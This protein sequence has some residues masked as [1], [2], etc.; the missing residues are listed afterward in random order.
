MEA[1]EN[2][3]RGDGVMIYIEKNTEFQ[4]TEPTVVTIGKFDGRHRGHQKLLRTMLE[5][6]E[7]YGY[8]TAVFTFSIAPADLVQGKRH[9]VITTNLERKNNLRKMG[10]DYLVEYPFT[11]DVAQM[12]AED[13]VRDI[14]VKQMHAKAIV[15]GTDCGFGYRRMGNAALLEKLAPLYGYQL[16]VI[17]KERDE[18]RVISS[19]YVREK[20]DLGQIEKANALLGEPYYIHGQVVHG[21]HI[22]QPILGY[23]TANLLPPP[24]KHLPPFG[25]YVSRVLIDGRFYG[26][27]TNIG[28]KPTIP[29]KD[30]VA[31][32]GVETFVFDY[33]GNLYGKEIE[34]GLLHFV[35]PER[36]MS[37]LEEL[38]GQISRDKEV[39]QEYLASHPDVLKEDHCSGPLRP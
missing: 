13:F 4:I 26:G 9:T 34:V 35:R 10:M 2:V 17:E 38:K 3:S 28:K 16:V 14:L 5:M 21:N 22:G 33:E 29:T 7:Q 23:P 31:P 15:V 25:V 39:G 27:I 36:K 24:E 32:V 20:L 12:L 18:D 19:T 6:K 11:K 37:G 8:K 30:G 1:E